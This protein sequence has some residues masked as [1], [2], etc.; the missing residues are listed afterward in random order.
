VKNSYFCRIKIINRF[1]NKYEKMIS[2]K[3]WTLLLL[4]ASIVTLTSCFD[5]TT[6]YSDKGEITSFYIPDQN[7]ALEVSTI[8]FTITQPQT[9]EDTGLIT[10]PFEIF[11]Y[12]SLNDPLK[13]VFS[14]E[15]QA[16]VYWIYNKDVEVDSTVVVDSVFTTNVTSGT[17]AIDF[18][19]TALLK[20]LSEDGNHVT[21]Y[22]VVINADQV[23]PGSVTWNQLSDSIPTG[24]TAHSK[25]FYLDGKLFVLS[26]N[27]D[28][29]TNQVYTSLSSSPDGKTWNPVSLQADF[30]KGIYHT[31]KIFNN[32]AYIIGYVGWNSN[33]HAFMANEEI[34]SSTDGITWSKSDYPA[35]MHSVF[36]NVDVFNKEL[37]VWGGSSV[38]ASAASVEDMPYSASG[39][40]P[41]PDYSV[42]YFDDSEWTQGA[43]IPSEMAVRF[44][45]SSVYE[46]HGKVYGGELADGTNSGL[47]WSFEDKNYWVNF[48]ETELETLANT[49]LITFNRNLWL[50]GGINNEGL[51][52]HTIQ[53]SKDGGLTFQSIYDLVEDDMFPDNNYI[54]RAK[55]NVVMTPDHTIYVIGGENR[56]FTSETDGDSGNQNVKVSTLYDIW[57]AKMKKYSN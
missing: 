22:N 35:G 33:S 30:P 26:G 54:M 48:P 15:G 42:W 36:K 38:N 5:T 57:E 27:I 25:A 18:S 10:N 45:T 6:T 4:T 17:T 39:E 14:A 43:N 46:D 37:V 7:N 9:E 24:L 32:T 55:Q 40:V 51:T 52:N 3:L 2:T 44:S 8:E 29:E 34:W 41:E 21:L 13:A 16:G 1:A 50:F 23:Y 49:K 53:V 56:A 28:P 31:I 19:K 20:V 47:F 11:P 12:G